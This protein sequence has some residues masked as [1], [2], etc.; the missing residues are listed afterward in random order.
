[1]ANENGLDP[2]PGDRTGDLPAPGNGGSDGGWKPRKIKVRGQDMIV[3]SEAKAEELMQKGATLEQLRARDKEELRRKQEELDQRLKTLQPL[4]DVN[5]ILVRDPVKRAKVNAIL[6]DQPIPDEEQPTDD[7]YEREIRRLTA[8]NRSLRA[9]QDQ[10]YG[11]VESR[12]ESIDRRDRMR[13]EEAHLRKK[14]KDLVDD[15][16]LDA[17]RVHAERTGMTLTTA[18]KDLMFDEI[19]ERVR[20]HTIREFGV[21]ESHLATRRSEIPT[22]DGLGPLTPETEARLYAD[23]DKFQRFKASIRAARRARTGKL[24]VPR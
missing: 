15:E 11:S 13:T 4:V 21:D 12:L 1:M 5:D 16:S 9:R 3:D 24:E 6:A 8:E 17:A 22:I 7:P 14:Y 19:P 2:T 18:F 20:E 10:A 23:P